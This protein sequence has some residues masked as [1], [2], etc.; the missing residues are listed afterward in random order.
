MFKTFA[1]SGLHVFFFSDF[2]AD[3]N[4]SYILLTL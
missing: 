2:C 1:H 3:S 4:T